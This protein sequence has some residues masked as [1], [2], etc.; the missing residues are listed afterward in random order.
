MCEPRPLQ[1]NSSAPAAGCRAERVALARERL[2]QVLVGDRRVAHVQA[3]DLADAHAL[4]GRDRPRLLVGADDRAHEEVAAPVL[5]LVLVDH[6][7]EHHPVAH[8][9]ALALVERRDR[10]ARG[11]RAPGGS[12][13][14]RSRCPSAAVIVIS[15][16]TG[17]APWETQG[18]SGD[19]RRASTRPRPRRARRRRGTGVPEPG[20]RGAREAAEHGQPGALGVQPRQQRLGREA[21]GVG[22]HDQ[23]VAELAA[24]GQAADLEAV[25]SPAR[26]VKWCVAISA[27]GRRQRPD[28]RARPLLDLA[29]AGDDAAGPAADQAAP[30]RVARGPRTGSTWRGRGAARR[31]RPRRGRTARRAPRRPRRRRRRTPRR[32]RSSR[33][34]RPRSEPPSWQR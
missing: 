2:A 27:S 12:R 31:R 30:A 3:H 6:D 7:A 29:P 4:A 32:C 19:A 11:A 1:V 9:L 14:P 24:V 23:R 22:E 5:G 16:P 33:R 34:R 13:A 28:D 25:A 8:Q 21:V 18:S 15:G 10:L 20:D 17:A 26:R